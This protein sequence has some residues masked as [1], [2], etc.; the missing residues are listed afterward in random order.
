MTR[1]GLVVGCCVFMAACSI[2]PVHTVSSARPLGKGKVDVAASVLPMPAV[3]LGYGVTGSTDV[4]VAA[5]FQGVGLL[6]SALVKQNLLNHPSGF[7]LSILGG[8]FYGDSFVN[9][10]GFFAAPVISY[11]NKK[12]EIFSQLRY[13]KLYYDKSNIELKSD[14]NKD[15]LVFDIN[16]SQTEYGQIDVG[17]RMNIGRTFITLGV[18]NFYSPDRKN[19]DGKKDEWLHMPVFGAGFRL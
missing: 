9:S 19:D 12:W 10:T 16:S 8:G 15:R 18:N 2:A 3:S 14:D 5:E 1:I 11:G 17:V 7:S 13:N 6:L 4:H